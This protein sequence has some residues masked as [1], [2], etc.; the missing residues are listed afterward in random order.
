MR[1]QRRR[2]ETA[3]LLV[4]GLTTVHARSW[5]AHAVHPSAVDAQQRRLLRRARLP[6]TQARCFPALACP[7]WR[8]PRRRRS[9]CADVTVRSCSLPRR[10]AYSC[11]HQPP[12]RYLR[13]VPEAALPPQVLRGTR[14]RTS[15]SPPAAESPFPY[16]LS[17]WIRL[18]SGCHSS[19]SRPTAAGHASRRAPTAHW[20]PTPDSPPLR[21][22]VD[23]PA[24]HRPASRLCWPV[25]GSALACAWNWIA[26]D[27]VA[28]GLGPFSLPV[29]TYRGKLA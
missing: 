10:P 12:R 9:G 15:S 16:G 8:K 20:R 11:A 3:K 14:V 6:V 24:A 4:C 22:G 27:R 26:L 7:T 28:R 29:F 19:R 18:S 25:S 2:D 1:A 23:G 13:D 21:R 5:L 17:S